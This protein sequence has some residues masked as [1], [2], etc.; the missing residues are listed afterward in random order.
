MCSDLE[1]KFREIVNIHIDRYPLMTGSD[2]Y[3][4][5]YQA[6]MGNSHAFIDLKSN[7]LSLEKE[8]SNPGKGPLEP[9]KDVISPCGCVWRIN[10]RPFAEMKMDPEALITA[11][12][13]SCSEFKGSEDMLQLYC[14]WFIQ[15]KDRGQVPDKFRNIESLF[16]DML[17][18]G[19]PAVHH[20]SIYRKAYSPAYRVIA[21]E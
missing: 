11:F 9:L 20:S 8:L 15:M 6:A 10:L 7:R 2:I 19:Y 5:I 13:R 12:I 14:S 1:L 4:L 21:Q 16:R 17:S 3:K 18:S